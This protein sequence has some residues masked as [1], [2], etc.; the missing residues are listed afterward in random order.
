MAL[1]SVSASA[2]HVRAARRRK[3]VHKG[4]RSSKKSEVK[5]NAHSRMFEAVLRENLTVNPV[6]QKIGYYE[7]CLR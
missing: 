6:K 3:H 2:E 7:R 5:E 4:R 1:V